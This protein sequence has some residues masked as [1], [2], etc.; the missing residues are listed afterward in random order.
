MSPFSAREAVKLGHTNVKVISSG[1]HGWKKSKGLVVLPANGL[2]KMIHEDSSYVLIDLRSKEASTAGH[3]KGAVSIPEADLAAAKDKFPKDKSAPVILYSDDQASAGAFASVRGWGYKNTTIL[4]GGAKAWD[5]KFFPGD[6]GSKIVYVKKLKPGE[7]TINDFKQV[8]ADKPADKV[9]LDVRD[10]G[11][12]T[13]PGAVNIPQ[14]ELADRLAELPKDKEIII[15]CNTG[16]MANMA[17]KTLQDNGYK[18]RYVDAVVQVS[19]DGS[20]DVSSK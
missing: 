20:F 19:D 12:A 16:I 9:I 10:S 2:K 15:H 14:A 6:P 17:L 3:I 1:L 5:G 13:I 7:I 8:A 18:A 11:V 4:N